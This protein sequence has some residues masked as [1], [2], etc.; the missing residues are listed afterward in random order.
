MWLANNK[1]ISPKEYEHDP[2]LKVKNQTVALILA[3]NGIVPP[4]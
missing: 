4:K 2:T 3:K 1:I